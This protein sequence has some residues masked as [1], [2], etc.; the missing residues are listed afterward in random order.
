METINDKPLIQTEDGEVVM[1]GDR[2]YNYYDMWPG[3]IVPGSIRN[4]NRGGQLSPL[5]D[6]WFDVQRDGGDERDVAMLNGQ[7]ICTIEF[8]KRRGFKGV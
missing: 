5:K 4:Y 6:L 2:I 8:A 1:E 3:T 7:R